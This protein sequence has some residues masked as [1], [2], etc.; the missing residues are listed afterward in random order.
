MLEAMRERG[1]QRRRETGGAAARRG[2]GLLAALLLAL[3]AAAAARTPVYLGLCCAKCG[4]N[5]PLNIPGGGIPETYEWRAKIQPMRMAMGTLAAGTRSLDPEAL[6]G[7]PVMMG[8]PTGRYMAVPTGM[9][10]SMLNLAVGYS[11]SPRLFGGLMLMWR[12]QAMDMRL[13]AMMRAATGREGF[14]MRSSG[15]GDTMLMAKWLLY[16]DDPLVP[17]RQ[18][19]LL[20]GLSLPTGSIDERNTRHPV[21]ARRRELLPYGMQLGSGTVD[22]TLGLLLQGSRSPWWWGLN[23]TGTARLY[24]NAR[25]WR[26]GHEARLDLYLMRQVRYD[27]VLELQL[28]ARAQGRIRGEADEAARGL[29]GHATQGDPASPL[30]TPLWDPRAYGGEQ[31]RLTAGVQW[32]PRPLHIL[33]LQAAL[34]LHQRLHGP[35]LREDWRVTLTWYFEV[36]TAASVRYRGRPAAPSRLGF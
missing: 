7:M 8:R 9:D 15:A 22:P 36:P 4:G 13:N 17:T 28:N 10:M 16:A 14:T 35:L 19:S 5:M 25:G 27:T 31:L 24:D 1:R 12:D 30:A 26:L 29:S 32:Q 23:A 20:A 11:F 3:P 2:T 18:A 33:N 6:L 21:P 34:P